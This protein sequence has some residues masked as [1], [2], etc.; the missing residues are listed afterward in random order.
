MGKSYILDTSAFLSGKPVPSDIEII[1]PESVL[2]EIKDKTKILYLLENSKIV[3]PSEISLKI[4]KEAAIRTGDINKLSDTDIDII[5]LS[6][7]FDATVIT[8]DFAI[9]N[10]LKFLNIKYTGMSMKEI[11]N[12][13]KW[14]YR[15]TGCKR[16][17]SKYYDFCPVCGS[18]LKLVKKKF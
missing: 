10:V 17:F 3:N 14:I 8:D 16:Y 13:F 18:P 4:A 5:A 7:E 12:N 9:Q 1:I 2:N 11:E 15:C 6:L